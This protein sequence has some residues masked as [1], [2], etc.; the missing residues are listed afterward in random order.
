MFLMKL[1]RANYILSLKDYW[2]KPET[3]IKQYGGMNVREQIIF[4]NKV[5]LKDL[6][7]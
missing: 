3:N 1:K 2:I 6:L 4:K 7:H 5:M